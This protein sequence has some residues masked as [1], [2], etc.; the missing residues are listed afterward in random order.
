MEGLWGAPFRTWRTVKGVV[1]S[2]AV[3]DALPKYSF[4]A[5]V[6]LFLLYCIVKIMCMEFDEE[7]EYGAV[8]DEKTARY[9]SK[10]PKQ[11]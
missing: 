1:P 9:V 3:F 4:V 11:D 8:Y 2:L 5:P 10:Q 7:E 6:P